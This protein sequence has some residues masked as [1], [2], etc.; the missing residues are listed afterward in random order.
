MKEQSGILLKAGTNEMELL[1]FKLGDALFGVNVA[2]VREIVSR[3]PTINIPNSPAIV[4]GS[5]RLRDEV[6]SLINVGRHFGM[7]GPETL[8]GNG[9]IIVMEFTKQRCGILVDAVEQI[10][11]ISWEKIKPPSEYLTNFNAPI[12]GVVNLEIGIVLIADF[13]KIIGETLG[14]SQEIDEAARIKIGDLRILLAEDSSTIR[15]SLRS[16]FEK[17]GIQDL[18][19]CSD[20][21][22]AWEKLNEMADQGAVPIDIVITDIEMP[23]LD[24]LTL[25]KNIKDSDRL[26]HLPVVLFSSI[27]SSTN[28][29]KGEQVGADAQVTKFEGDTLLR[30]IKEVLARKM[31]Q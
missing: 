9:L 26:R 15:K 17:T 24:G 25:T 4:E 19:V 10:Y 31:S 27:I 11:R 8:E 5:F 13:E 23:R 29:K 22:E 30:T 28:Q 7:Q 2:K 20:G 6:L 14:L 3:I 18:T 21:Q 1:V 16:I 12:T